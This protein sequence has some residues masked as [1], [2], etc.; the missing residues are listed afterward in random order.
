MPQTGFTVS[1]HGFKFI[2]R[3]D[4]EFEFDLPIL[5]A[6]DLG[7]IVYG[8]C[9]GMCFGAI[10]HFIAGKP[11]PAEVNAEK[12]EPKLWSYLWD[13]QLDSLKLPVVP[14]VIEWMLRDEDDLGALINRW[15]FPKIRRRVDKGIPAVLALIRV[16]GLDSPTKNHQVLAIGYD[17][18]PQTKDVTVELYDPNHPGK[19]PGIKMNLAKPRQGIDIEQTTGEFLRGFFVINYKPQK[20]PS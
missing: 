3:F 7:D 12:I 15:E 8:L 19:S 1:Q 2:N 16:E 17:F 18:D 13:R 9:G 14:K 5:G 10:D 6:I 20:P 4:F 11:I